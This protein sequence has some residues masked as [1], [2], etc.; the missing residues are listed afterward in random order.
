[1]GEGILNGLIIDKF[2]KNVA[3]LD[4]QTIFTHFSLFYTKDISNN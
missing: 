4:S 1:M 3:V 2:T